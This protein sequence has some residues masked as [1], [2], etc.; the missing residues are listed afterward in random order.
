MSQVLQQAR[1]LRSKLER[2]PQ[3]A[4]LPLVEPPALA[5]LFAAWRAHSP[6]ANRCV[7]LL[8]VRRHG[9]LPR[10]RRALAALPSAGAG[11]VS[12]GPVVA[13]GSSNALPRARRQALRTALLE[14]SP[15]RKGPFDVCGVR[16]DA[17]WRSDRKWARVAPHVDLAGRRV[18]DVGCGNGYYGWRMLAAGAASVTGI[19]PSLLCALQHGAVGH[20][21]GA[22][23]RRLNV[24][25]PLRLEEFAG[26]AGFDAVFSM[27]V[28]YHRRDP[29]A[30]VRALAAQARDDALLVLE[31][32]VVD[33]APIKPRE[34]YAR[35]N[36][37]RVVPNVAL[38]LAWL[39]DAGFSRAE[40]V[41][42]SKTTTDEQ[43]A[44]AW[45][46][47]ESL[48]QAL[49]PADA[50]RTVEGYPAPRRA[51]MIARR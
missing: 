12:V 10:W 15:W 23:P 46:P 51:V 27:G 49:D 32:L 2:A 3:G 37:V 14:L 29:A 13:A 39:R 40:V 20:Y 47:F 43:R 9:D 42:V 44:T 22:E 5:E 21:L 36:N 24:V 41:D 1:S 4:H 8:R 11:A 45:M 31:S 35:M 6:L 48:A 16:I 25:L 7:E 19:D 33:G 17:E 18:L 28:I 34:R 26:A 38:L 30:H 50:T